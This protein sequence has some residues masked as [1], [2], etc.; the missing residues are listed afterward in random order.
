MDNTWF[1]L[2]GEWFVSALVSST[3]NEAQLSC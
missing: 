3:C 1:V 2:F